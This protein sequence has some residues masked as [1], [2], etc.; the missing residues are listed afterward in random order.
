MSWRCLTILVCWLAIAWPNAVTAQ[1]QTRIARIGFLIPGSQEAYSQYLS[2]FVAGL[3]DLGYS[4]NKNVT[5]DVRWA[6][7]QLDRLPALAAELVKSK[8]DVLVVSSA[9]A[10]IA[11][12]KATD[13]IPI[14][15]A[16]GGDPIVSGVADT[17]ARPQ[18][19]LTGISNL[20]EDLS[21]KSLEK[22]LLMAPYL[23]RVGVMINPGNAAHNYRLTEIR[24]AASILGVHA[25]ALT[26]S[27]AHLDQ[28]FETVVV[29]DI[30][31]LIVLSDGTFLTERRKI[32]DHMAKARVPAIYQIREFVLD[33]GMM[34]YG[35]NIGANYRRAAALVVR[36]LRG[37]RPAD[38]PIERPAKFELLINLKTV[39]ALGR[40]VPRL[41]LSSADTI[42]E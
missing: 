4:E 28:A 2:Q 13:R 6:N 16:S 41:L 34:S 24:Q 7:G 36:I 17:Y 9:T 37:T 42:V 3:R 30:G 40:K 8:V 12:Q 31:G 20:A 23:K 21:E 35:I 33:G 26:A 18:R 5:L 32:I 27:P 19:N 39:E 29:D 1:P 14:V 38:L 22:L 10:A 11:A 15:Q 25:I